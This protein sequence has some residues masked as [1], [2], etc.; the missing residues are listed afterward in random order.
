MWETA[1]VSDKVA[2]RSGDRACTNGGTV[3]GTAPAPHGGM[4]PKKLGKRAVRGLCQGNWW[5]A[6]LNCGLERTGNRV[7]HK[8]LRATDLNL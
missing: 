7:R 5:I 3:I 4:E 6:R 8:W 2:P 1:G